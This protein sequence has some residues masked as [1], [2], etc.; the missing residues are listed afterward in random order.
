MVM[1]ARDSILAILDQADDLSDA[2]HDGWRHFG[3]VTQ[4]AK[5]LYLLSEIGGAVLPRAIHAE[6]GVRGC[7]LIA[8]SGRL[9]KSDLGENPIHQQDGREVRLAR[10]AKLL[11][12]FAGTDGTLRVW[13]QPLS[14][15]PDTDEIGLSQGELQDYLGNSGL[16]GVA[17]S[18]AL[19]DLNDTGSF[20]DVLGTVSQTRALIAPGENGVAVVAGNPGDLA[21]DQNLRKIATQL[22]ELPPAHPLGRGKWI[23]G[24]CSDRPDHIVGVLVEEANA[25]FHAGATSDLPRLVQKWAKSNT[26]S[27]Q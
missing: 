17:Q 14:A 19:D 21:P 27:G 15:A 4:D 3:A 5:L 26:G 25:T 9:I 1:E 6:I 20:E 13:A 24:H 8:N 18:G 11:A 22:I 12:E 16:L 10:A 23:V 2:R 7:T